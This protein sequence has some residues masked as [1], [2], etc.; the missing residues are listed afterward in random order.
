[1]T[2]AALD[3]LHR[4]FPGSNKWPVACAGTS[5]GAKRA[6]LVAPLLWLAGNRIIGIYLSGINEDRLTKG[7]R[8]YK[9]AVSFLRTPIFLST[10]ASDTIATPTQQISVKYSI[11][12][13]GFSRIRQ[14]IFPY[15]H[16]I[17]STQV[18]EALRWFRQLQGSG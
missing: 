6:G 8:E 13:T 1:M 5:G 18:E 17:L 10:G 15:G 11:Q 7:Y 2:L 12:R 14:D 4:G 3:A 9:P 16:I